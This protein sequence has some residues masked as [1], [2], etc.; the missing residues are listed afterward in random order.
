MASD[1]RVHKAVSAGLK[2]YGLNVSASRLTTGNH[3]LYGKLEQE[4]GKFFDAESATLASNG[5]LPN[6]MVAQ[7]VAGQ[8]SHALID[9]RAHGSL[10]DAAEM[11]RC[12]VLKFRHRDAADLE[13]Q[14]A[15]LG[16]TKPLVLT[17][18]MFAHDGALAPIRQYLAALPSGGMIL[19]DDAHAAGVLGPEGQGSAAH[20]GVSTERIIRTI[21]LSKAFGVYGGAVLG[22]ARLRS[23]IMERSHIFVGNTPL[24]LPLANA[25]VESLRVVK[26][27]R[28]MRARLRQN[29]FRVRT[30]LPDGS[31]SLADSPG[32][33]IAWTPRSASGADM[34]RRRL[35]AKGIHPPFIRYPGAPR[36]GFFRFAISSEHS[37]AQ[38]DDLA[39]VLVEARAS[40]SNR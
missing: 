28:R 23:A 3:E 18:G 13:R 31:H 12:E 24:P 40:I 30:R 33:I 38:L 20:A 10:A 6:L 9:E 4:M 32:P 39:E 14:I 37:R 19:L 26:A 25:A 21:T 2:L 8:F 1:P 11:M 7:A 5:Y 35:L 29:I 36:G 16:K 17:D 22:S 27:D 15:R 34:L